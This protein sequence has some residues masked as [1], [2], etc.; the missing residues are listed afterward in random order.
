[1]VFHHNAEPVRFLNDHQIIVKKKDGNEETFDFDMVLSA[2]GRELNVDRLNLEKANIAKTE[3]GLIKVDEYLRTSNK[4]VYV[5]GDAAGAHQFTHA[6]ELHAS[7]IIRNMLSPFKKPL[8][9]DSMAWVTFTS[10][11]VAAFGLSEA[12]LKER[13]TSYE[14]LQDD[15]SEDDRAI[16]D[17]YPKSFV[18]MF[19][20]QKGC[21]LGGSMVAPHAGEIT[22]ELVLAQSL[23]L[24][25]S[26]LF[27]KVY[28]YPT[29]TRINRRVA[30]AYVGRKLT[31]KNIKILRILLDIFS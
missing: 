23:K 4:N 8:N 10:P 14:V 11:E 24:P 17:Q 9:T 30:G 19:V 6:A 26:K 3:R 22:Q 15:F 28:P 13:G 12:T 31:A 1:M 16:V 27:A 18:K 29:A 7:T 25:L 5:C 2:I 21:L 20:D